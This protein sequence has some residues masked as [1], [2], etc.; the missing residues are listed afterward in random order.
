MRSQIDKMNEVIARI[1]ATEKVNQYLKK[2]NPA[3]FKPTQELLMIH[4]RDDEET[5]IGGVGAF[6]QKDLSKNSIRFKN[7]N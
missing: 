5:V 7:R 4:E 6:N 3:E 1:N 2:K